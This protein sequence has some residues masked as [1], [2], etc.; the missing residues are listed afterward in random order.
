MWLLR[1]INNKK[2]KFRIYN[3]APG[4]I[5]D[6]STGPEKERPVKNRPFA[7]NEV[8]K[9]GEGVLSLMLSSDHAS[10]RLTAGALL[11]ILMCWFCSSPHF[12]RSTQKMFAIEAGKM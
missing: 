9:V 3:R 4:A 5:Q 11:E 8:S 7:D 6:C 12:D 2:L 1:F 10:V